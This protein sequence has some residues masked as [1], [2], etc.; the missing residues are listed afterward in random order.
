MF[1]TLKMCST[2]PRQGESEGPLLPVLF[3]STVC[4]VL[5]LKF[6]RVSALKTHWLVH[7]GKLSSD[8]TIW[9]KMGSI[10]QV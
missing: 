4:S 1:M 6:K 3:S 2:A 5:Y 9:K 10:T 8:W 7:L